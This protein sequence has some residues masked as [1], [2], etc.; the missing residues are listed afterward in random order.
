MER[1]GEENGLPIKS[2]ASEPKHITGG[3]TH[4]RAIAA[5]IAAAPEAVTAK[6]ASQAVYRFTEYYGRPLCP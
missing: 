1:T 5:R 4:L 3:V 6:S 2:S